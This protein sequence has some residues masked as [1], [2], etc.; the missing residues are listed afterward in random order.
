MKKF[1]LILMFIFL[2]Q[3][4]HATL[5]EQEEKSAWTTIQVRGYLLEATRDYANQGRF[6]EAI[7][8]AQIAHEFYGGIIILLGGSIANNANLDEQQAWSSLS[9]LQ[10]VNTGKAIIRRLID[11]H[12]PA[13]PQP[14]SHWIVN[15]EDMIRHGFNQNLEF[16][17]PYVDIGFTIP[18]AVA[19]HGDYRRTLNRWYFGS[20]YWTES[21]S[22]SIV[23]P[24]RVSHFVEGQKKRGRMTMMLANLD[25]DPR[26][27]FCRILHVTKLSCRDI[28]QHYLFYTP[29]R[30]DDGWFHD[31]L[32]WCELMRFP[33]STRCSEIN[34][35]VIE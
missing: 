19:Q 1:L 29:S 26:D 13:L 35:D 23:N 5:T 28:P 21:F 16:A 33:N 9:R 30:E 24:E 20:K 32:A 6:T 22:E 4:T 18:T 15:A 3:Y 2:A 8:T 14:R 34:W 31:N 10:Q 7:T 17:L 11:V 27:A 25:R 12:I